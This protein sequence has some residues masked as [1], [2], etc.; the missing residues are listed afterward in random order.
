MINNRLAQ[1]VYRAI[2]LTISLF[3]IIESFGLF[4][5]QTP[6]LECLVYYTSLSNYLCFIVMLVVFISTYRHLKKGETRGYNTVLKSLKFYSSIIILVTFLVYNILLTDNMFGDG[7]N[8]LGNLT[9]HIVC[10][11]MFIIDGLLFDEHK[12]I[13]WYDTLLCTVLPLIYVV[14]ILIR[15]ALLPSDYT[16][17][18]YP[19]FFLDVSDIG[20]GMVIGWVAILLVVFIA[21]AWVFYLYDKLVIVDGKLKFELKKKRENQ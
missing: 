3:G 17:V 8:D 12:Q 18:I 11:L 15:G 16:G 13:K 4:Y 10:P 6:N 14:V 19:Y 2:F 9:K 7:W 5:G 1:L 20:I 21:I